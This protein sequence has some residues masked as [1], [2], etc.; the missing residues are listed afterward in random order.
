MKK[1][2]GIGKR[3]KVFLDE[4]GIKHGFLVNRLSPYGVTYPILTAMLNGTRKIKSEEYFEICNA[5]RV[6][7]EYFAEQGANSTEE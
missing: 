1:V 6:P 2:L 7:L 3:I 4:N 5:L